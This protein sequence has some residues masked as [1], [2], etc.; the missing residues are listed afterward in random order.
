MQLVTYGKI[1]FD[2]T[3]GVLRAMGLGDLEKTAAAKAEIADK[4]FAN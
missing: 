4:G 2:K 1:Q 3:P